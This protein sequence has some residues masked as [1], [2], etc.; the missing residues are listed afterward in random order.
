MTVSVDGITSSSAGCSRMP[1]ATRARIHLN[2]FQHRVGTT[3]A[4]ER[5][6]IR[7]GTVVT[8]VPGIPDKVADILIE[9]DRI[10]AVG[11]DLQVTDGA[12]RMV[13]ASGHIVIPGM[14]DSHRHVYQVLLRGLASDWSLLQ[15]LH[16]MIETL[17]SEFTPDDLFLA[18][19]LG[20]LDALDS[21]VTAVFD[22][23]QQQ[24]TPE[25]TN[26]LIEGLESASIR[27]S[28][29]SGANFLDL[30]ACLEPPYL[31]STPARADEVRRLRDRFPSDE[32][33]LTMGM[34][35][36]GPNM[37]TMETVK[38]DFALAR[39]LGLHINLHLGMGAFSRGDAAVVRLEKEGLLADDLT[40]GHCNSL[41]DVEI[42]LMAEHGVTASVTPED[43]CNMGHG[44]P[45]VERLIAGGVWPNIGVDTCIV[46]G[47]DPFTAMRF[48][49]AVPR[50]Q[51]NA[52]LLESGANPW[53][54]PLGTR[55]V[56]RMATVEGARALGQQDRIGTIEPGKQAD[57]VCVDTNHVSMMP[58]LMTTAAVVHHG[59]RSTV[60]DV[61]VGGRHV[62]K[63]GR[64]V[65]VD[66]A[67]LHA[68]VTDAAAA[69]LE[70]AGV[71]PGWTPAGTASD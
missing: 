23:S 59:S 66:V 53:S 45:P 6:L 7:G 19:R 29:G 39:E 14:V 68:K 10:V 11:P 8:M 64:L 24:V 55:D 17:G 58:A 41:S 1:L 15:Y 67:A 27:A 25:H 50:A 3:M 54:I 30:R 38:K 69:L 56:L 57:L 60:S 46:V 18:N 37:T 22:W 47:G 62:K 70:R 31:A 42:A 33:L 34:A 2:F 61:F 35:A 9:G 43:E 28:F 51:H 52:E 49:L 32:G 71:A 63:D 5:T 65:G 13:D 21:G 48:A 44:W 20:A 4:V 26:A 36:W 40:F 12:A 16:A